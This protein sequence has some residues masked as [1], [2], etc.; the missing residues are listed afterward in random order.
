MVAH[1]VSSHVCLKCYVH[2]SGWIGE[3]PSRLFWNPDNQHTTLYEGDDTDDEL[4]EGEIK[5][6]HMYS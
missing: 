1:T 2:L 6:D 4:E 5:D 3:T